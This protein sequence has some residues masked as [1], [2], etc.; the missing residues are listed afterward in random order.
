MP[1]NPS[2]IR[3]A[4]T[5]PA[6]LVAAALAAGLGLAGAAHAQPL[7]FAPIVKAQ[8]AKVVHINTSARSPA[9]EPASGGD[10]FRLPDPNRGSGSGF[11]VS[12][13]GYI[14]TNHHVVENADGVEVLLSD[15][16]RFLAEIVGLDPQTDLALLKIAADGLPVVAFGDSNR[17]EV[18]DWVLAIGNP[19]GLDHTVTAGIISAKGRNIFDQENLAYG[20]FLQTDAAINPGNSGGPLFNLDG[21]VVGVNSAISRKGQGIGFAVPS[22]LV[23]Q[24]VAQ[25]REFGRVNRG[26]LG[27]VILEV[28][29]ELA[30]K[31]ALPSG[32]HG[33]LVDEIL[34]ESPARTAGMRAGDVL[35]GFGAE[36]LSKVPQLQK[37]VAL[38]APGSEVDVRGLRRGAESQPWQPLRLHL[39]I[40]VNPAAAD[41]GQ[42]SPLSRIG[43][44]A[45]NIPADVRQQIELDSEGG[46]LV[47]SVTPGGVAEEAGLRAGD[48]IVEV[49]RT[50]VGS[51]V[52]L[53]TA[54]LQ[55]RSERIPLVV[56]RQNKMLFLVLQRADLQQ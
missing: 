41:T 42:P 16:R 6:L 54:L 21:Q 31:L 27:V 52:A 25:L 47:E 44:S 3:R 23:V 48:I 19:L 51:R 53:E 28:T 9:G 50:E 40:G 2:R 15:E 35:T 39:R 17:L 37:L 5:L 11:I 1:A 14:V 10:P 24:V 49:N 4:A 32:T 20:E 56:R 33:V 22:N 46:V 34:P 43:L 13:D 36:S 7:S 38:S 29:H 18:G 8:R 55:A 12:P 45:L 26:W 30:D